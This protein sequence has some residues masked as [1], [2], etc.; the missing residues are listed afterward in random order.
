[1]YMYIHIFSGLG[2]RAVWKSSKDRCVA[3]PETYEERKRRRTAEIKGL[4]DQGRE[5]KLAAIYS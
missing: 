5:N 1:M 3:K 2:A 4:K